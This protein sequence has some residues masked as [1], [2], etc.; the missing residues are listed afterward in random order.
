MTPVP[1]RSRRWIAVALAWVFPGLGHAYLRRGRAAIV[2][3]AVVTATFV[4]GL[5]FEGRLYSIEAGQPLS[6]LATFAVYGAGLLNIGARLLSD[7]P[8]GAVLKVTYEYGCAFLLTAG[9]MNLLL[10]LDAYDIA[11]GRKA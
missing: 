4:L 7:N 6:I 5:S 2:Y 11:A 3:A 10:M 8:G 1:D 9:L